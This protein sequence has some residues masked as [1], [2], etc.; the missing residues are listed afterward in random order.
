MEPTIQTQL[1]ELTKKIDTIFA[2][3]EK[4]RKYFLIT[5]WVTVLTIVLPIIGLAFFAPK[6]LQTYTAGIQETSQ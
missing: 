5:M 1:D 2:S 6:M 3:V 4:S